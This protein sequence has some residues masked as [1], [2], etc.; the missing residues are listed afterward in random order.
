MLPRGALLIADDVVAEIGEQGLLEIEAGV[1]QFG[2]GVGGVEDQVHR[3]EGLRGEVVEHLLEGGP[4][5]GAVH[6][7]AEEMRGIR[8]DERR[9]AGFF[10]RA[11][12]DLED[13]LAAGLRHAEEELEQ[14]SL[15]WSPGG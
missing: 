4:G 1:G 5:L 10:G 11:G 13:A 7:P 8:R 6:A 12:E 2:A 14:G 9:R 15:R 3:A